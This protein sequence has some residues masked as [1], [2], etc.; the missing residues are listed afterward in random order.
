MRGA[1]G[2]CC[3]LL[4]E[5]VEELP[6]AEDLGD[7]VHLVVVGAWGGPGGWG[8]R[9][10][11]GVGGRVL[12]PAGRGACVFQGRRGSARPGGGGSV[13]V[14]PGVVRGARV[15]TEEVLVHLQH[16]WVIEAAEDLNLLDDVVEA[17][18]E[19]LRGLVLVAAGGG[20]GA[21][22]AVVGGVLGGGRGWGGRG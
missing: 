20:L 21:V 7:D 5:G 17:R 19:A 3:A 6:P 14:R 11:V 8:L 13:G 12:A 4:E 9:T 22:L 2:D 16:G 15:R 1:E 10:G 18:L